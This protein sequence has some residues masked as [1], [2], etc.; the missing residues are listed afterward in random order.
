MFLFSPHWQIPD[1]ASLAM[2]LTDKKDNTLSRGKFPSPEVMGYVLGVRVSLL[3]FSRIEN[4][5]FQIAMHDS[6]NLKFILQNLPFA[7]LS[8]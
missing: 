2:S 6:H 4:Y 5:A 1:G 8:S 3:I 7:I